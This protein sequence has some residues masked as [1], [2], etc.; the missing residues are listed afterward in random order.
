MVWRCTRRDFGWSRRDA[1]DRIMGLDG[2]GIAQGETAHAGK[3][4]IE[5]ISEN[6]QREIAGLRAESVGP[7]IQRL[8]ADGTRSSES[9]LG[10]LLCGFA[11]GFLERIVAKVWFEKFVNRAEA[12]A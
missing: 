4:R 6:A 3:R 12:A 1:G 10:D 7:K 5:G 8:D 2:P 11:S 9:V